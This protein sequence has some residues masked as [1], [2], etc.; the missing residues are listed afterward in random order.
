M[1]CLLYFL[2]LKIMGTNNCKSAKNKNTTTENKIVKEN[3]I[4]EPKNL[5]DK[6][7]YPELKTTKLD[8]KD[9]TKTSNLNDKH[10][11]F[12]KILKLQ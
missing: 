11:G 4:C 10:R 12:K 7:Q 9:I 5:F 2:I 1:L 3:I 6:I 8:D